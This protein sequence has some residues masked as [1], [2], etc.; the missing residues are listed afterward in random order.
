MRI[1]F[2][3]TKDWT[4]EVEDYDKGLVPSHRLFGYAEVKA[5]GHEPA[6][7][8]TSKGMRK[9]FQRPIF[10]RVYQALFTILRQRSFDCIFV[11]NEAAAMPILPFKKFGLLRTP[12]IIFNTGLMHPRNETGLRKKLWDFFLPSVEAI[13]S[14][15]KMELDAV[16][17][18]FG[19]REDRQFFIPMLVDMDFCKPDEGVKKGDYCLAVGTNEAK[20]Y[21]TLMKAFPKN[22]KLIIVTDAFNAAIVEKNLEP[23]MPIKVMQ[24]VPI[25]QLKQMY[26][27]AK[28]ILNPLAETSYGSG[29]T[30]VLENMVLGNTVIVS[31]VGG[32][33][34]YFEDGFSA[35]GVNANDVE[36]W[37]KKIGD[38]LAAPEKFAHIG[39]DAQEYVRSFSSREF[40]RKLIE[41]AGGLYAPAKQGSPALKTTS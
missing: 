1:L 36:D 24:A 35:I 15:T 29:H 4:K 41:I 7:C 12:I 22:E 23:D 10:W 38:F 2:L 28:V 3:H 11:I 25:K 34:D 20:D 17:K 39:R 18:T 30:V 13:V 31:R 27:E 19:L 21:P 14:Q 5:M 9:F 6:I 32:M 16:W 40:A 33:L 37:K 26:Q 8:A